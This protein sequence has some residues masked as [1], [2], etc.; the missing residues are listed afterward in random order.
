[1][2]K[3][4]CSKVWIVHELDCITSTTPIFTVSIRTKFHE[5][6]TVVQQPSPHNPQVNKNVA[7][8]HVC[9]TLYRNTTLQVANALSTPL[10]PSILITPVLGEEVSFIP[11]PLYRRQKASCYPLGT[12]SEGRF[13]ED[14]YIL[15]LTNSS[16]LQPVL[17][18]SS[19]VSHYYSLML[20]SQRTRQTT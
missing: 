10:A 15:A 17:P 20:T 12:N 14:K 7:I 1:M 8:S 4:V 2:L 11:R 3:W 5:P 19:N 13:G 6:N 16:V 18:Y 9:F